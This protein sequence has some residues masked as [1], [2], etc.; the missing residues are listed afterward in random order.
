MHSGSLKCAKVINKN[1]YTRTSAIKNLT[2]EQNAKKNKPRINDN[3][4]HRLSHQF[5]CTCLPSIWLGKKNK[6][7]PN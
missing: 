6:T 4:P 5:G 2:T 3:E 7:K 1:Y